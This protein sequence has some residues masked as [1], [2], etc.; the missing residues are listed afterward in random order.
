MPKGCQ[1]GD[2]ERQAG[3][4]EGWL[5]DWNGEGN[6]LDTGLTQGIMVMIAWMVFLKGSLIL[7]LVLSGGLHKGI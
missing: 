5:M 4:R 2:G 1:R 3:P 7:Y 6:G